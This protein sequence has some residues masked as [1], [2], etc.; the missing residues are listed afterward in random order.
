MQLLMEGEGRSDMPGRLEPMYMLLMNDR[1][2]L[3]L[4]CNRIVA[5]S[6]FANNAGYKKQWSANNDNV[7]LQQ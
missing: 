1:S 3:A 2:S 7:S 5:G 6:D 4:D